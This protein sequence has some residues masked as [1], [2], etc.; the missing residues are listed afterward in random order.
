[1]SRTKLI[2]LKPGDWKLRLFIGDPESVAKSMSK[3]FGY[4]SSY[5]LDDCN[6]P[7]VFECYDD[8]ISETVIVCYLPDY[9]NRVLV[10]ECVHVFWHWCNCVG[11]N[12]VDYNS[13]EFCALFI[14]QVYNDI[15]K[16]KP[17]NEA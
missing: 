3:Y 12:S 17:L 16:T 7:C 5:Y 13:Q 6:N 2:K 14:E 4:P 8:T 9:D 1:M 10:H 11:Y 15:V